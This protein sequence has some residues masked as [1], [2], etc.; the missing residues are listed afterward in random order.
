MGSN[1]GI[2]V[3]SSDGAL[4]GIREG[5][6]DGE[7]EGVDV[8]LDVGA[9]EGAREGCNVGEKVGWDEGTN[10]GIEDGLLL[11]IEEG[12][13]VGMAVGVAD[14][15][16]VGMPV[17]NAVGAADGGRV[18]STMTVDVSTSPLPS[19]VMLRLAPV[20]LELA[21]L[22]A[23]VKLPL[24]VADEISSTNAVVKFFA[25]PL[26]SVVRRRVSSFVRATTPSSRTSSVNSTSTP[27][28]SPSD[29]SVAFLACMFVI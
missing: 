17:G 27:I 23:V 19:A 5:V 28:T 8:G 7:S 14:G 25:L 18:Y 26:Y 13:A 22:S 10:V 1:D 3:G 12:A 21:V 15:G 29:S 24:L 6:E 2:A 16:E 20:A 4:D 11:G 9:N